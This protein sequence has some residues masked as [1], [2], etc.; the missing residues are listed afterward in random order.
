M[1]LPSKHYNPDSGRL[2]YPSMKFILPLYVI[3]IA[4]AGI[5]LITIVS[6]SIFQ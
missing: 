6:I 3:T 2:E 4:I 1:A 5:T